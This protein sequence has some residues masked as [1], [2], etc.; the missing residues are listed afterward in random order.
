MENEKV[1]RYVAQ[2]YSLYFEKDLSYCKD[3]VLRVLNFE[4]DNAD[5]LVLRAL[6]NYHKGEN[7]RYQP[8]INHDQFIEVLVKWV[9]NGWYEKTQEDFFQIIKDTFDFYYKNISSNYGYSGARELS[10]R[11]ANSIDSCVSLMIGK[12][13]LS[14]IVEYLKDKQLDFESILNQHA[15]RE[16]IQADIAKSK[17]RR[18]V[19][20]TIVLFVV[21]CAFCFLAVK[22]SGTKLAIVGW[23]GVFASGIGLGIFVKKQL[24]S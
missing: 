9:N 15:I 17:K 5:A 22:T 13:R 10:L 18:N 11:I 2:A 23:I 16:E 6:L 19:L 1:S 20:I 4:P 24:D 14:Q 7:G 8:Y 21:M 3:Y 12:A